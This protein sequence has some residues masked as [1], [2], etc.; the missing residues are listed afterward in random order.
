M[1][2]CTEERLPSI[3]DQVGSE[4]GSSFRLNS[5]NLHHRGTVPFAL[6]R[7]RE[8]PSG[9]AVLYRDPS[10]EKLHKLQSDHPVNR[11]MVIMVQASYGQRKVFG[12][13]EIHVFALAIGP[14]TT[15]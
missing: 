5:R 8:Q 9:T 6:P 13:G 15:A 4:A 7:N 1:S 12:T 2:V 11:A 10:N 3:A 14:I